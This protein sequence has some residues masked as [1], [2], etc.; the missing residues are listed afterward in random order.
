MTGGII[1][2]TIGSVFFAVEDPV[3]IV[4]CNGEIT[5]FERK[6]RYENV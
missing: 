3:W 1:E 4:V 6:R 5:E 2:K